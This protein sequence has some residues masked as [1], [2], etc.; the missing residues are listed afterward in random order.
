MTA[1]YGG[2]TG[3]GWYLAGSIV[4][5]SAET[6]TVPINQSSR[7]EFYGWSDGET[8][9]TTEVTVYSPLNITALF[10]KQYLVS[11]VPEN[12]N[13]QG[14]S[15]VGY[16]NISGQQT[17]SNSIY[18]FSGK[19]YNIEYIY[20]KNVT[21]ATDYHF[22]PSAPTTISFKTPVYDV[23]IQTQSIFGS[24]VNASL[25]ITFKN[26]THLMLYSGN[27]GTQNFQNV[28][29]GYVSGYA[30][31]LGLRESINLAD[32]EDSYLTFITTSLVAYIV[33]GILLIIAVA[34]IAVYYERKRELGKNTT[35]KG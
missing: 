10:G 8:P 26:N 28:P 35:K 3:S 27:T 21:I 14:I 18:L 9:L 7:F 11:L 22:T 17:D 12:S 33:A 29:Y 24:T 31:Y 4:N 16:Y 25:N 6:P 19:T 34:R 32:G 1:Q 13:G 2:A 23:A 15:P 20:Y 5:I 30:N